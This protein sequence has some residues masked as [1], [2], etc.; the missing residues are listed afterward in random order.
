MSEPRYMGNV[1]D[2]V[3]LD[4]LDPEFAEDLVSAIQSGIAAGLV[5]PCEPKLE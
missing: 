5:F 3:T 1:T 4:L 2:Y